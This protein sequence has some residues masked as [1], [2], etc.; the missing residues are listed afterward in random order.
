MEK[1][2][3]SRELAEKLK[4]AEVLADLWPMLKEGGH[5]K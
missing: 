2:V 3:V 5:I 1:F 4:A